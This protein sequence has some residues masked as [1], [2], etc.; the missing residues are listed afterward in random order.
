MRLCSFHFY[1]LGCHCEDMMLGNQASLLE[2]EKTHGGE[3]R[4]PGSQPVQ[5]G[6]H[7]SEAVLN[8]LAKL[9]LLLSKIT[10]LGLG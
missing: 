9:R 3:L 4:L 7:V 2:D 1:P 10:W 8:L 6:R 5:T